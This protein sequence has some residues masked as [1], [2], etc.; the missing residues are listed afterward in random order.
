MIVSNIKQEI[1]TNMCIII[2]ANA[3]YGPI[4]MSSF[5]DQQKLQM[6]T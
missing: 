3:L 5:Q 6:K 1:K 4:Q 2:H